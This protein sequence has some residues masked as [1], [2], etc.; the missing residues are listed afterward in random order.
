MAMPGFTAEAAVFRS[1][2]QYR[3]GPLLRGSASGAVPQLQQD[4]TCMD[5]DC[6]SWCQ[7]HSSYPETCYEACQVPCNPTEPPEILPPPG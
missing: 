6:L 1:P 2:R 4:G 3:R 7:D 5:W